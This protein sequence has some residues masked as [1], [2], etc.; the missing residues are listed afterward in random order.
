MSL[1]PHEFDDPTLVPRLEPRQVDATHHAVT[2]V[3]LAVPAD[4]M[5]TRIHGAIRERSHPTT[6]NIEDRNFDMITAGE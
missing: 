1:R 3:V 4:C 6:A 2:E 5:L